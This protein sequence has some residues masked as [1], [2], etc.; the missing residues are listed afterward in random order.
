M[1]QIRIASFCEKYGFSSHQ[2]RHATRSG[3]LAKITNG[4]IDEEQALQVLANIQPK[5]KGVIAL[6]NEVTEL[7]KQLQNTLDLKNYY[8]AELNKLG[9]FPPQVAKVPLSPEASMKKLSNHPVMSQEW[10]KDQMQQIPESER[11]FKSR[12]IPIPLEAFT[13]SLPDKK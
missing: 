1:T 4:F 6:Q 12:K 5:M 8:E 7:K 13:S 2:I 11:M 10:M 3:K 9:I